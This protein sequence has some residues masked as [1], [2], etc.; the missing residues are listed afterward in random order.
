M[1]YS[2]VIFVDGLMC[3]GKTT[4]LNSL[5]TSLPDV[6]RIPEVVVAPDSGEKSMDF[7]LRNDCEK[8]AMIGSATAPYVLVDRSFLSTFAYTLSY[9]SNEYSIMELYQQIPLNDANFTFVYMREAPELSLNRAH[10]LGRSLDGQ[11][12][13]LLSITRMAAAYDN[14]F[15]D[16]RSRFPRAR[17]VVIESAAYRED[18][19]CQELR[20]IGPAY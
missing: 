18:P 3:V 13:N 15:T 9:N 1:K 2:K 11:W 7:F 16:L 10:S 17:V 5:A 8:L 12:R 6:Q 14:L 19:M 4:F 20:V